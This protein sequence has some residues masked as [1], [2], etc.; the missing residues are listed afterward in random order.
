[1]HLI[2]FDTN[3][4]WLMPV[5]NL[6][7]ARWVVQNYQQRPAG[8]LAEL[9]TDLGAI[10]LIVAYS[11]LTPIVMVDELILTLYFYDYVIWYALTMLV[12]VSIFIG[13][14]YPLVQAGKLVLAARTAQLD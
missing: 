8:L 1:M 14:Y 12:A 13:K 2:A 10:V 5:V 9:L 4:I 3:R 11:V 6:L 7:F